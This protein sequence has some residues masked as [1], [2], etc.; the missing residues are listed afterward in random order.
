VELYLDLLVLIDLRVPALPP[1]AAGPEPREA[2]APYVGAGSRPPMV[3]P[4]CTPAPTSAAWTI[5]TQVD[6]SE[7]RDIDAW[8]FPAPIPP[9]WL[10]PNAP[11]KPSASR[12]AVL[13]SS[14]RVSIIRGRFE[15]ACRIGLRQML[16]AVQP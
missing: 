6:E 16:A 11:K 7:Y 4:L 9:R 5:L 2:H 12:L 10:Q 15:I 8:V 1:V 3:F 13:P 14:A